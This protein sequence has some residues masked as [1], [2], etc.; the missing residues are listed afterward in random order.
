MC[1]WQAGRCS[2]GLVVFPTANHIR[3]VTEERWDGKKYQDAENDAKLQ[4]IVSDQG[5]IEK[6]HWCLAEIMGRN[7]YC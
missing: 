7:C 5:A 6:K 3:V 4:G 2:Q 1:N